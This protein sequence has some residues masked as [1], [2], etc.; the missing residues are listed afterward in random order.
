M[1]EI[2]EW[3]PGIYFTSAFLCQMKA[4]RS[5]T[6][7]FPA[8]KVPV[9]DTFAS[10][11]EIHHQEHHYQPHPVTAVYSHA[12]WDHCWGTHGY[13]FDQVIAHQTALERFGCE[14]GQTLANLRKEHNIFAKT[15]VFVPPTIVFTQALTLDFGTFQLE[16]SF[17]GGHTKD[18]IVGFIPEYGL[19]LAGDIAEEIPVI[20]QAEDVEQWINSL[21]FWAKRT[22][23]RHILPGHGAL[24]N[25]SLLENNYRYLSEMKSGI[26]PEIKTNSD[27]YRKTHQNNCRI[28]GLKND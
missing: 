26:T 13:P 6:L 23:V 9:W 19:L 28:M 7:C 22:D 17:F 15:I 12:D 4:Y 24:A 16:L 18:S 2:I 14:M 25:R 21:A 11:T 5:T 20:N 1:S 27:F 3:Q 10:S 8:A